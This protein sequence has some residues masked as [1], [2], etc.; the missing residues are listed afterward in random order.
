[1][2]IDAM[3]F[4]F[5]GAVYEE[6]AM[7]FGSADLALL[8]NHLCYL[9]KHSILLYHE[10]RRY[11]KVTVKELEHHFKY[12][13]QRT[14]WRHLGT[15]KEMGVFTTA[16]LSR[17][18][19]DRSN[20]Y[21]LNEPE[22][23]SLFSQKPVS[24]K[25]AKLV[26]KVPK[27]TLGTESTNHTDKVAQC[28]NSRVSKLT[29]APTHYANLAQSTTINIYITYYK[30]ILCSLFKKEPEEIEL[31]F[32]NWWLVY[33]RLMFNLKPQA[34]LQCKTA[35]GKLSEINKANLLQFTICEW[36]S[37]ITE[38]DLRGITPLCKM[39]RTFM[40]SVSLEDAELVSHSVLESAQRV[41]IQG[42]HPDRFQHY[43]QILEGKV[44]GFKINPK[45]RSRTNQK[46]RVVSNNVSSTEE[47]NEFFN[48]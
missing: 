20:Y 9:K 29:M 35:F 45:Y 4:K 30:N 17:Q 19:S 8:F 6:T 34:K 15:L 27:R 7:V 48:A 24:V 10:D 41:E 37:K 1:M 36:I 18:P 26:R 33:H 43:N 38:F 47:A 39:A 25:K 16:T 42:I 3:G 5:V 32:D 44:N 2:F 46:L 28:L 23:R 40:N 21:S 11:F 31:S 12:I 14:L 22:I 13:S